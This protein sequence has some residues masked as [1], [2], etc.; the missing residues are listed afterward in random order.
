[1]RTLPLHLI[2]YALPLLFVATH[3]GSCFVY[4]VRP[5]VPTEQLLLCFRHS[6]YMPMG[7]PLNLDF[8]QDCRDFERRFVTRLMSWRR[9]SPA[10]AVTAAD[11]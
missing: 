11:R 5:F 3:D 7:V 9:R 4:S 10:P 2:I 1:M 6:S 8:Q